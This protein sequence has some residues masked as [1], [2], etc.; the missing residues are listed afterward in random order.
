MVL[1][2]QFRLGALAAGTDGFGVVSIEGAGRFG[3]VPMTHER[4]VQI[5]YS[6]RQIPGRYVSG[7]S[8]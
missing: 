7:L 1:I 6:G 2:L 4:E 8:S 3:M 5:S